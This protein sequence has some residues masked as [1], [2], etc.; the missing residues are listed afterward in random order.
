VLARVPGA[1]YHYNPSA[2][3]VKAI[4][5]YAGVLAADASACRGYYN[6]TLYYHMTTG[7]RVLLEGYPDVAPGTG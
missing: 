3:Y 2:H 6:W 1:L 7:D 5:A 4:K